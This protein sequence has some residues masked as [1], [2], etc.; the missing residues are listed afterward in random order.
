MINVNIVAVGKLKESYFRDACAE[1][2]KRLGA[3]CRLKVKEL[4]ESRLPD[5]PSEKEIAAALSAEGKTMLPFINAKGS[6]NIAMCIEGAKMSSEG[7]AEKISAASVSGKSTLNFFIGSSFGISDEIKKMCDLRLSMSEMTFPHM[8]AR[9]ML[10]EQIY[11]A[12]RI[13]NGGKYH[14]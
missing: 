12:F 3:F 4:P 10:L 13:N 1:Y 14:K 5:N 11:R 2:A 8:L 7:L 9:V 6:F